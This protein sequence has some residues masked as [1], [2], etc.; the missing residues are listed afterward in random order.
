M[1]LNDSIY[2]DVDSRFLSV[3]CGVCKECIAVKQMYTVQRVQMESLDSFMYFST[4]TYNN[5]FLPHFI[6]EN[7]FRIPFADISHLQNLFKRLRNDNA[8]GRPFRYFAVSERGSNGGRPHFHILWFLPRY[9][10]ETYSDGLSL[11]SRLFS[12]ILSHW[13]VNLGSK[14]VPDYHPLC[15]FKSKFYRGRLYRNFDTHFVVPNYTTDG[16]SSLAFY[17]CKYLM[18]QNDKERRL[19]Q[20]LRLNLSKEAYDE[21]FSVVKSRSLRS[22][23]FGLYQT[24]SLCSLHIV[25]YL[26]EC[27]SR[28]KADSSLNYPCFFAPDSSLRFP[29]AP[30]YKKKPFIYSLKDHLDFTMYSDPFHPFDKSDTQIDNAISSLLSMQKQVDAKDLSLDFDFLFD[31]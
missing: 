24:D 15:T 20:A 29:L 21:A 30:Y 28:S 4:L 10:G 22:E 23:H 6:C 8:F 13:S 2:H 3:P 27:I 5:E 14:R 16:V 1:L 7:G 11:E 9:D 31:D 17:V 26:R 18:K 25:K 19:Q 12:E